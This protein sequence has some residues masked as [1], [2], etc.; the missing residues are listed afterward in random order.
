V[1]ELSSDELLEFENRAMTKII[2]TRPIMLRQ[3]IAPQLRPCLAGVGGIDD[4][5]ID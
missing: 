5:G 2:T 1:L 3:P 4:I